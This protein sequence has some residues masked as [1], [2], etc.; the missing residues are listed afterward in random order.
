M[1]L[2]TVNMK[3]GRNVALEGKLAFHSNYSF[4]HVSL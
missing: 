2:K 1:F 4:Q 3:E